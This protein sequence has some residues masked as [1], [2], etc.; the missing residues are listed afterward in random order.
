LGGVRGDGSSDDRWGAEAARGAARS[1]GEILSA[2]RAADALIR[3]ANASWADVLSQ[4]E[5]LGEN[6]KLR[7]MA[8]QLR[9]ENNA[10]RKRAAR[11]LPRRIL[12]G[13]KE[14]GKALLARAAVSSPLTIVTGRPAVFGPLSYRRASST[15]ARP[16]KET[17]ARLFYEPAADKGDGGAALRLGATFDQGFLGRTGVRGALGD[18]AQASFWYRRAV[19]LGNPAAQE[20]LK[21]LEQQR[22]PEPGSLPR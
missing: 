14:R 6:E 19:D 7:A 18:P 1:R 11:S 16:I 17:G 2:G 10:L 22:V 4:R 21:N 9:A 3:N 15:S 8:H 5:L 20:R 13:A 12:D